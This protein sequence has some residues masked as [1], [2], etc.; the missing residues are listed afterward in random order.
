MKMGSIRNAH[1]VGSGY[2][3]TVEPMFSTNWTNMRKY[4]VLV[5]L[6]AAV[7]AAPATAA[8]QEATGQITSLR[9]ESVYGFV[10]LSTPIPNCP[11]R[12]WIDMNSVVQRAMYATAM[13]AL[14]TG[15]QV[16]LRGLDD[17]TK[18]YGACPIW[19]IY[20]VQ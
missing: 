16:T 6:V 3:E 7:A 2:C 5:S 15:K 12:L 4:R 13:L 10:S 18:V 17:G 14:S 20:V 19:D 8:I 9:V 1:L 11:S